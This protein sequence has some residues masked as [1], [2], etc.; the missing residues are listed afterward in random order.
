MEQD[1]A[2]RF[3]IIDWLKA[4]CCFR[5]D[6]VLTWKELTS[7]FEFEGQR[8]CL[9]GQHGIW[10]PAQADLPVSITTAP[11]RLDGRRPYDDRLAED[12]S[13][14]YRYRGSDPKHRDN[15]GLRELMHLRRPLAYFHGVL[16]GEYC[17][18]SP[19]LIVD[20]R[21]DELCFRVQV[22]EAAFFDRG[23]GAVPAPLDSPDRRAY[24]TTTAIRRLHQESFRL[25]VLRAYQS[26]CTI[27]RLRHE[28]LLD[29]AH[30]L[31]DGHERG[32]PE[33]PNGLA[34]C[35]IH[36]AAFDRNILGVTPHCVVEIRRDL[37]EEEDGPMLRHGIQDLHGGKL[38]LPRRLTD[39][40]DPRFLGER[41]E[42]FRRAQ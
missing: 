8:V 26:R 38:L 37:L 20:E 24:V 29:A 17:V 27:C 36:H 40:P 39:R 7:G 15:V 18:F 11:P 6:S 10:K 34:L 5:G 33:V 16:P 19:V 22:E 35:K 42:E 4:R 14:I 28:E 32:L 30:I 23:V 13:L 3:A 41:Y 25:R 31:P 1:T 12:G 21:K 2:L 9:I